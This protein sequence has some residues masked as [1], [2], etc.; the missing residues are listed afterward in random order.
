M[1]EVADEA[2]V[3]GFPQRCFG[4]INKVVLVHIEK[5]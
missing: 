3:I 1:E 4:L 2:E 5:I